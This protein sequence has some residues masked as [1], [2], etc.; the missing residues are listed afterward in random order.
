MIACPKTTAIGAAGRLSLASGHNEGRLVVDWCDATGRY[1]RRTFAHDGRLSSLPEEWQRELAALWRLEADVNNGAYLQFL[2]NWGR[3]SYDYASQAL[4]KI[5]ARKMAEIIDRCQALVD[6]HFDSEAASR[7]QL[8]DVMPN[9][10]IGQDG[11]LI[12]DGGSILPEQVIGRINELSYE[13]MD[14]P[15]DLGQLGLNHYRPYIEGEGPGRTGR[16]I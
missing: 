5:G 4:K 2:A 6:E 1:H 16:R 12:K 3:E 10:V 7:E 15:E 9:A 11:E 13:F 8:Q 14:Y